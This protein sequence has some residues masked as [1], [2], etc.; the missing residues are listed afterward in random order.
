MECNR[1]LLE[2]TVL[3]SA[4]EGLRAEEYMESVESKSELQKTTLVD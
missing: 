1:S 4:E 2:N 3:G